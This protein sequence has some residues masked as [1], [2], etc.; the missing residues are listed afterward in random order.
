[1]IRVFLF[2]CSFALALALSSFFGALGCCL[3]DIVI[4]PGAPNLSKEA[5]ERC[6]LLGG[7]LLKGFLQEVTLLLAKADACTIENSLI[8]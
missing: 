5:N 4:C 6:L 2:S 8:G 1:L 3:Y 7:Q